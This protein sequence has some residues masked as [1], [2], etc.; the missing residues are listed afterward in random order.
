MYLSIH[1]STYLSPPVSP[2]F[3]VA[4]HRLRVERYGIS[5]FDC[6][7]RILSDRQDLALLGLHGS[8]VRTR[9]LDP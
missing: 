9:S 7:A 1:P 5:G 8:R 4:V 2:D 3:V 6:G